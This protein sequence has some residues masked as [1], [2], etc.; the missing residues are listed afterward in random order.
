MTPWKLHP[1]LRAIAP[2]RSHLKGSI[3]EFTVF[4]RRGYSFT[5]KIGG[6]LFDTLSTG[7]PFYHDGIFNL[8]Y[9]QLASVPESIGDSNAKQ[10]ELDFLLESRSKF[11]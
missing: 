6:Y 8:S 2:S 1:L 11:G 3:L 10:N 5:H 7:A 4:R 9:S